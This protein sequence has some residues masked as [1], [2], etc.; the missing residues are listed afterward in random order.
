MLKQRICPGSVDMSGR[1][2]KM[3][4]WINFCTFKSGRNW[5]I[6]FDKGQVL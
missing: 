2:Y 5:A 4:A 6:N 1:M 3:A